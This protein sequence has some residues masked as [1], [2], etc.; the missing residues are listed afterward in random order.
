MFYYST[1]PDSL[2]LTLSATAPAAAPVALTA[3]Q[4]ATVPERYVAVGLRRA[5][6]VFVLSMAFRSRQSNGSRH[7]GRRV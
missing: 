1:Q 4:L 2:R 7:C 3:R 6:L 5:I